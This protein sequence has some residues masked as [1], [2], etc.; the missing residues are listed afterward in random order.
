[1]VE[2]ER[3]RSHQAILAALQARGE[4]SVVVALVEPTGFTDPAQA[5]ASRAA[6]ARMQDAVVAALDSTDF[7]ETK[8]FASVPALT[9][10]LRSER[11]LRLLTGHPYVRQV[12]LDT[13]GSGTS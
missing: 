8:R 3:S 2:T 1:M 4:A 9:G 12:S 6:I 11:G 7:R 10:L 5:S 13:G